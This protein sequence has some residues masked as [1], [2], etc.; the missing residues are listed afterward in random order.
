MHS[1]IYSA[2]IWPKIYTASS[3]FVF[4]QPFMSFEKQC[5]D[6]ICH[7]SY[8]IYHGSDLICHCS[9]LV[10]HGSDLKC[11]FSLFIYHASYV[12]ILM[13]KIFIC[14]QN[15]PWNVHTLFFILHMFTRDLYW[16][17]YVIFSAFQNVIDYLWYFI[18]YLSFTSYLKIIP[19]RSS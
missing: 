17:S 13:W 1:L 16:D 4:M 10:Y 7:C 5:S 18:F 19:I 3:S 12:K 2:S 11:Y 14:W 9:Y 6:L 8:L 15:M